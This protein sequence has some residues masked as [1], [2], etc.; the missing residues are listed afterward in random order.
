MYEAGGAAVDSLPGG[1][2]WRQRLEQ[3]PAAQR[4]LAL[5]E[6]HLVRVTERDRALL[7]AEMV[8]AFTWTCGTAEI[9]ERIS[10]AAKG[11]ATELLYAPLG[12]DVGRELRSFAAAAG[13]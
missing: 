5:H 9:R 3:V 13:L 7:N 4:H 8:Q 11:G 10:Q 6:D 12:P 2:A 1:A